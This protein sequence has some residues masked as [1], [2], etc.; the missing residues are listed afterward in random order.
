MKNVEKMLDECVSNGAKMIK[1]QYIY[2]KNLSYRPRFE[3]GITIKSKIY[4]IKRPYKM[5]YNRLKKLELSIDEQ[6][7]FVELCKK[8]EIIPITT[9]FT[10]DSIRTVKDMGFEEIKVASYD[11]A[12]LALLN[13]L[14]NE[15]NRMNGNNPF[16]I[17][18]HNT[19]KA[20]YLFP[21]RRTLVAPTFPEPI[22][23][24]SP[25]PNNFVSINAKGTDPSR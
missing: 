5:E 2:A 16:K 11:C 20:R 14:K 21:V 23:L 24:I 9:V 4:S 25:R 22:F 15:F 12:S 8:V 1:L 19:V 7:R 18:K 13:N 10:T 3:N 17:S 6:A